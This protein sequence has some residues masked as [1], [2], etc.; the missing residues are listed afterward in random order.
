MRSRRKLLGPEQ[1]PLTGEHEGE[2]VVSQL[3][4]HTACI[5]ASVRSFAPSFN[6]EAWFLDE[7]PR[8]ASLLGEEV[9]LAPV[10]L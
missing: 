10:T 3:M 6:L 5:V 8:E 1:E 4:N 2:P 7:A 9:T